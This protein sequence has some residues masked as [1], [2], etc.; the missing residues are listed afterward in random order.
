[1]IIDE[2]HRSVY[3]KYGAIFEYFDSLLIGLTATPRDEIDR[4]TY[5]LFQLEPGVPTDVYELDEAVRD[6]FLVPPRQL[7][8]PLK[9]QREGI[10]YDELSEED[11]ERWEE[12]EWQEDEEGGTPDEVKAGAVNRWL[13]NED[14][15]D[16][17]LQFVMENGVKTDMGDRLGKTIVF[18]RNHNHAIFIEERFNANYPHYR[19]HFAR[20]IDNYAKYPG[21]LIEEFSDKESELRMAI[22]VDMLDTGIDVPEVV[23]LVFF[24]PIHSKIKFLQMMGRGT[25]LCPDLFGPGMD[26]EHFLVLDFCENLEYFAQNPEGA[27]GSAAEPLPKRL[28]KARLELLQGL[29]KQ[30]SGEREANDGLRTSLGQDA[31]G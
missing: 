11:K 7:S 25:R 3:Q 28:F 16:K 5:E 26:K 18:A 8:V 22:S 19:G 2:A 15:V 4:N 27:G 30:E 14:T 24:K 10:K 13:F 17:V 9:Y 6:G 31:G 20:V 23:N 29:S 1:V 12:L 21:S